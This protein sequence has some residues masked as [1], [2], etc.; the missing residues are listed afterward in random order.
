MAHHGLGHILGGAI[1]ASDLEGCVSMCFLVQDL[2]N[3]ALLKLFGVD[4]TR[5]DGRQGFRMLVLLT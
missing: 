4:L 3:L 1:R 5:E 2:D